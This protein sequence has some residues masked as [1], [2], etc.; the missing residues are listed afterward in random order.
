MIILQI[1]V[2]TIL[3]YYVLGWFTVWTIYFLS[4]VEMYL[5]KQNK[6]FSYD[7]PSQ[8]FWAWP[9]LLP[10]ALTLWLLYIPYLLLLK[11]TPRSPT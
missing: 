2:V 6:Y 3:A 4:K 8:L 10:I 5:I 11:L 7:K 1:V 9:L